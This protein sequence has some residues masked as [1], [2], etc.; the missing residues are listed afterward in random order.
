MA[1]LVKLAQM[2]GAFVIKLVVMS[3][4]GLC[5][6]V[7][8]VVIKWHLFCIFHAPSQALRSSNVNH[9]IIKIGVLSKVMHTGPHKDT[10]N[11]CWESRCGVINVAK[12]LINVNEKLYNFI[13]RFVDVSK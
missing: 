7:Q 12:I 13:I 2:A 1:C 6:G 8:G 5:C 4:V 3:G 11:L 10:L 9:A